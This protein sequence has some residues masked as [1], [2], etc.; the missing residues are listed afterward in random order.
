MNSTTTISSRGGGLAPIERA[1]LLAVID[2]VAEE[3]GTSRER[4][5]GR[6][7][8]EPDVSAR[9]AAVCVLY[10]LYPTVNVSRIARLFQRAPAWAN[11]V[12]AETIGRRR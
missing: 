11:H 3:W 5:L 12:V 6:S 8:D 4:V 10:R 1:D 7:R 9:F 2:R